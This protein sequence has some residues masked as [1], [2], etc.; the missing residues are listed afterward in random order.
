MGALRTMQENDFNEVADDEGQ[1]FD[2]FSLKY[3]S[4]NFVLARTR[5]VQLEEEGD[6]IF[7]EL[8][9][10][11]GCGFAFTDDYQCHIEEQLEDI[12]EEDD[13]PKPQEK[14]T[15]V[16]LDLSDEILRQEVLS[17]WFTNLR[18]TR[19]ANTL[20]YNEIETFKAMSALAWN[21]T[22][23]EN[24]AILQEHS[25]TILDYTFNILN[26]TTHL[27]TSYFAA[28]T[29]SLFAE[30]GALNADWSHVKIMSS[31][32]INWSEETGE[33]FAKMQVTRSREIVRLL[34][35]TMI[36]LGPE[37]LNPE[38]KGNV[39]G[40]LNALFEKLSELQGSPDYDGYVDIDNL[41]TA[42]S[43]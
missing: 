41:A 2:C 42:L 8:R 3:V 12:A 26:S 43:M 14:P 24:F 19:A 29:L 13:R 17:N 27:P 18:P 36:A 20:V 34:S 15:Q 35:N 22:S 39:Q 6:K 1:T 23:A 28:V 30:N 11:E 5:L 31:A 37:T 4:D 25:D 38:E 21:L 10:L 7:D 33:E 40:N 32:M 16:T 9:K